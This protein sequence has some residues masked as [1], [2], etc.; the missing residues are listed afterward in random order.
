M[1]KSKK[2]VLLLLTV[3]LIIQ[4]L[5]GCGKTKTTSSNDGVPT[6]KW[7]LIGD[8]QADTAKVL[9]KANEIIEKK[10]GAKLDIEF[11]ETGGF[12]QKM[13]MVMASGEKYDL[14]FTGYTNVYTTAAENGGLLALDDMLDSVPELKKSIPDTVWDSARYNG[15]IYAVPN[16]QIMAMQYAYEFDKELTDKYNFDVSSVKEPEDLEPFLA[17]VK[18]GEPNRIPYRSNYGGDMWFQSKYEMLLPGYIGMDKETGEI[19]VTN[20]TKLHKRAA[21]KLNDWYNKGYIR[22]DVA[23]VGND[24][25]DYNVRR[26]AVSN[27]TWK[28]GVEESSVQR[29][30]WQTCYAK[31][32]E[33]YM[34]VGASTSTMIGI[35]KNSQ[36]PEK[37]LKFIE[38]INTD[39]ELYNLLCFGIEGEHYKLVDGQA[40]YI[41]NS[42]YA[43]KADWKFGNQ[44]NAYTLVGQ[45]KDLWEQTEK[46][47]NEAKVSILN[48]FSLDKSKILQVLNEVETAAKQTQSTTTCK[49]E[50]FDKIYENNLKALNDAGLQKLCDLVK[51]QVNDWKKSN[52]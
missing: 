32:T 13:T 36:N 21:K 50:E 34:P 31:I 29:L 43:P 37:A 14:C 42:G 49:P 44:F 8:K 25:A 1:K 10:I 48:G 15:K 5:A 39:K 30:G 47:N 20:G 19:V 3:S 52:K 40:E 45:P 6:L 7:Y 12:Q 2:I 4:C 35:S 27:N 24:T 51:E 17:A 41:E 38:L 33:P 9:A 23:S 16:Q 22:S 11:V 26:Y 18:K 46:V 28:P